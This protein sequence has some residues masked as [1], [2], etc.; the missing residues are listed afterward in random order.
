MSARLAW[1]FTVK[2]PE[3][4]A[5]RNLYAKLGYEDAG[6]G[7]FIAEYTY[8]LPDNPGRDEEPHRYLMKRLAS[9]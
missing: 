9:D 2:N 7:E 4:E 3:N 1:N 8:F 6:V 5:A